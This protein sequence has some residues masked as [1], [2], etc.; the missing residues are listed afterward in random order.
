[1]E[2]R[3]ID[4][5]GP[6]TI[7]ATSAETL[8]KVA[9]G[10]AA[11]RPADKVEVTQTLDTRQFAINGSLSLEVSATASG[12]VPELDDL[13]DLAPL[14][15]LAKVRQVTVIDPLMVKELNTWGE[16]VAPRTE[17]RWSITLDGDAIRAADKASDVPF[18]TVKAANTTTVWRTYQD[19]DPIVLSKASVLLD[20]VKVAQGAGYVPPA[21]EDYSAYLYAGSAAMVA[22]VAWLIFRQRDTGP[23]PPR[24]RDVFKLPAAIDGFSVVA[25]LRKLGASP[26]VKFTAAQQA[27]LQQ[28]IERVQS[29]CFGGT[30][31]LSPADLKSLAEKWLRQ[32]R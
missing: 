2:L 19:I 13:L 9:G 27:E 30:A 6:V 8:L 18:P 4:L 14:S 24:A 12:L 25:L 26:L 29:G 31:T 17:R 22:F 1:M 23:R 28:D 5:S 16:K 11:P 7:P 21:V 20:R 15:A 32:L 3:F 10:K